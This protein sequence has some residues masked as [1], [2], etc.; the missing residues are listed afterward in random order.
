MIKVKYKNKIYDVLVI[1]FAGIEI[2][3]G[4]PAVIINENE[5]YIPLSDCELI[6]PAVK[7]NKK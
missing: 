1:D 4:R 6:Y 3:K 7:E 2:A 5:G